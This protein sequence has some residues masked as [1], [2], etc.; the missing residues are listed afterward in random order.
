MT[1]V[2][3]ASQD[4]STLRSSLSAQPN[5]QLATIPPIPIVFLA[6]RS[7]KLALLIQNALPVLFLN[8]LRIMTA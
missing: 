1:P 5:V 2:V 3:N 6:C 8:L 4:S 7:A